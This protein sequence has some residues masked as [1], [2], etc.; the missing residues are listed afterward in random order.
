M[1]NIDKHR[2]LLVTYTAHQGSMI[3]PAQPADFISGRTELAHFKYI[4]NLS[5]FEAEAEI[6]EYGYAI[7]QPHVKMNLRPNLQ[8]AFSRSPIE[9]AE[10]ISFLSNIRDYLLSDVIPRLRTFL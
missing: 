8:I 1:Q 3:W 2:A 10:V 6:A 5:P 7:G 9:G 4:R